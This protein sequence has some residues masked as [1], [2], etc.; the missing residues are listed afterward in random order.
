LPDPA[1]DPNPPRRRF[2]HLSVRDLVARMNRAPDFGYDDEEEELS[3][4]LAATGQTWRW[5]DAEP[6]RVEIYD[7]ATI[8]TREQ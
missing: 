2:A 5:S 8:N 7:A 3:R 1:T 4:R 6:P